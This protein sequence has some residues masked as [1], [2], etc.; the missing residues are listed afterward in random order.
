[1]VTLNGSVSSATAK[2][3]AEVIA[4]DTDGVSRVINHLKI[5]PAN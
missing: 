1:V 3:A 5:E 2:G 4:Q